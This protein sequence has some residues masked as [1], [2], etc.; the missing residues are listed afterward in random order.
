V[1][2]KG[3]ISSKAWTWVSIAGVIAAVWLAFQIRAPEAPLSTGNR[4]N[5]AVGLVDPVVIK[6]TMLFDLAPLFL[7]TEFNSSRKPYVPD[8]PGSAFAGFP[9]KPTFSDSQIVLHLPPPAEVPRSPA[10]ALAGDPPGAPFIGFGRVD[11]KTEPLAPRAAYVEITDAESGR[12]VF[13]QTVKDARPPASQWKPME[14]LAAVDAAGLVGPPVLT[15]HSDV[16]D[17]DAYFGQYLSEDLRIGQRL[18]PGFYRVSV[19]P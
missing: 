5:S 4:P 9:F 16:A 1:K 19:G 11:I 2:A 15:Q 14:F 18:N 17:V 7:P 3:Q 8:E 13:S 10:E 12:K 6:R